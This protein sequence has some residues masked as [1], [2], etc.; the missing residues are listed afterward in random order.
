MTKVG[1]DALGTSTPLASNKS[2]HA[3]GSK[4]GTRCAAPQPAL[5]RDQRCDIERPPPP[6]CQRGALCSEPPDHVMCWRV[7]C[8]AYSRAGRESLGLCRESLGLCKE[9]ERIVRPASLGWDG[10]PRS[11]GAR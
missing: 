6:D 2:L 7:A 1:L 4:I 10:R 8:C 3:I 5:T 11:P 9:G